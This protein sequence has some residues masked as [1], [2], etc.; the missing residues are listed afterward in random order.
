MDYGIQWDGGTKESRSQ[1]WAAVELWFDVAVC[2]LLWVGDFDLSP[3]R[4]SAKT[5]WRPRRLPLSKAARFGRQLR[6]E[7]RLRLRAVTT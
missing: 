2:R 7:R 6:Q 4:I 5:S 1:P 3:R